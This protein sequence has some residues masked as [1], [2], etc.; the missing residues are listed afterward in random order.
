MSKKEE[1][2]KVMFPTNLLSPIGVFL[3]ENL[4]KLTLRKKTIEKEDPFK[5]DLRVSDNAAPDTEAD[6]QF[7]HARTAAIKKE[8]NKKID[9]TKKALKRLEK[10]KYGLCEDC[11]KMIDTDRLSIYPEATLCTSCQKKRES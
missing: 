2:K 7:G 10:G 6:E 1:N 11:G 5:N 4:Q 9:Q 8:L 3:K